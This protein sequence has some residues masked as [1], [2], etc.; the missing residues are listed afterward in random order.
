MGE[1]MHIMCKRLISKWIK[2]SYNTKT[3]QLTRSKES[4]QKIK[5]WPINKHMKSWCTKPVYMNVHGSINHKKPKHGNNTN[6][7]QI[8]EWINKICYRT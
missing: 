3:N 8:D 5:K 1:N 7:H 2:N 6:V 4:E